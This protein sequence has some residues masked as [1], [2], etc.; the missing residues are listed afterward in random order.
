MTTTTKIINTH[1][2]IIIATTIITI[3]NKIT[4]PNSFTRFTRDFH[5]VYPCY[6]DLNYAILYLY[7]K[8]HTLIIIFI[9]IIF[10]QNY[11]VRN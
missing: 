11:F 5:S 7:S 8:Y 3:I 1:L 9:I 4:I 10:P 6:Y 2:I